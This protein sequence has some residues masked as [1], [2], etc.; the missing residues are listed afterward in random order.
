MQPSI[1]LSI[2]VLKALKI[3]YSG[4]WQRQDWPTQ[5]ESP[6]YALTISAS[7][8]LQ[9]EFAQSVNNAMWLFDILHK[10]VYEYLLFFLRGL[11]MGSAPHWTSHAPPADM[12][13][14]KQTDPAPQ[15]VERHLF[16][17]AYS[18]AVHYP[19]RTCQ[20]H[21]CLECTA[22]LI[23]SSKQRIGSYFASK[24]P[25]TDQGDAAVNMLSI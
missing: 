2:K 23:R 18:T 22:G 15:R 17:E 5:K 21:F 1:D 9:A 14:F 19:W 4:G 10:H 13:A 7:V 6:Y 3:P 12:A 25:K 24:Y 16:A 8:S 20:T 11:R